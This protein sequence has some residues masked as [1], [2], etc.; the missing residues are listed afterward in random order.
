MCT[1]FRWRF[2][3]IVL[4]A[5]AAGCTHHIRKRL[6]E[7]FRLFLQFLSFLHFNYISQEHWMHLLPFI[8]CLLLL[9]ICCCFHVCFF[10]FVCFCSVFEFQFWSPAHFRL[11]AC[12]YISICIN[13]SPEATTRN[14]KRWRKN[15]NSFNKCSFCCDY[16]RFSFCSFS[17]NWDFT[18]II[19][20]FMLSLCKCRFFSY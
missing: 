11:N 19:L 13:Y 8:I 16:F 1:I 18:F 7:I 3:S 2:I 12:H 17:L 5:K 4:L 14:R 15:E 20:F 9:L 6:R 10:Y